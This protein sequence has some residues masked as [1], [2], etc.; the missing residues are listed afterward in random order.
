VKQ[1]EQQYT[2]R[3]EDNNY[4]LSQLGTVSYKLTTRIFWVLSVCQ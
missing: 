2:K 4:G 1:I 3:Q